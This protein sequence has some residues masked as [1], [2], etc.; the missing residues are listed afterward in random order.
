MGNPMDAG[1][2]PRLDQRR[3][4]VVGPCA[5]GKTTLVA[6]L[7]RLGYEALV[8]GQEHSDVATLWR[9]SDPDLVIALEIDLATL[10]RR[11]GEE[12]P[13]WLYALQ[14]RRLRDA[15]AA[16]ALTLD[17]GR[18]GEAAVLDCVAAWL[19][20]PPA[21][22]DRDR[23]G[24]CPPPSGP[25]VVAGKTVTERGIGAKSVGGEAATGSLDR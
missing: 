19:Q 25:R 8:C 15:A 9:H 18:L 24:G 1:H 2:D 17:T 20:G 5:S 12:W 14:R 6:G 23:G 22:G 16:A 3:I 7:R 10:R 13:E 11:R 4:V 21:D